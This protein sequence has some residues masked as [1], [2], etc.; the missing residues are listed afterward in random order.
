M[1]S[2]YFIALSHC[3]WIEKHAHYPQE[4][5]RKNWK[6][7]VCEKKLLAWSQRNI[8]K[9]LVFQSHTH[10]CLNSLKTVLSGVETITTTLDKTL[11][12]L[13]VSEEKNSTVKFSKKR[14]LCAAAE[15]R[16]LINT[17]SCLVW[18]KRQHLA[19]HLAI[20]ESKKKIP[21]NVEDE[22]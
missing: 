14:L 13:N 12:W 10:H 7:C 1:H 18:L 8:T 22:T 19:E 16:N 11:V 5:S 9:G 17:L 2:L 4:N 20:D 15:G 6:N 3:D 21:T